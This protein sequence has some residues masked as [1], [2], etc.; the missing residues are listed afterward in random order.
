MH[1][2]PR[3]HGPHLPR[4]HK[5]SR[6]FRPFSVFAHFVSPTPLVF[7]RTIPRVCLS[8]RSRFLLCPKVFWLLRRELFLIATNHQLG[9]HFGFDKIIFDRKQGR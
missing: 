3:A 4:A 9:Q 6:K 8:V 2:G 5:L 7:F 1:T